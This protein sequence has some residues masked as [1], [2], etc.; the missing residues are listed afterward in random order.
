[1]TSEDHDLLVRID[2]NVNHLKSEILGSADREGRLPEAEK[3]LEKHAA[4]INQWRGALAI[5]AFLLL[6]GLGGEAWHLYSEHT[7]PAIHSHP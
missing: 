1:M 2:E 6:V 4:Q 3:T 7:P 5:L